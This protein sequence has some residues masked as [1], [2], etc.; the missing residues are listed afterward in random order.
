[1]PGSDENGSAIIHETVKSMWAVEKLGVC[2]RP[3]NP[4]RTIDSRADPQ[5]LPRGLYHQIERCLVRTLLGE[6]CDPKFEGWLHGAGV[7]GGGS[8]ARLIASR[9]FL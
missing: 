8:E 5:N 4:F 9:R 3:G 6:C 1:M 7:I 2:V